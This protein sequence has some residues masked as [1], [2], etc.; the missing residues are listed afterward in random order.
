MRVSARRRHEAYVT[1]NGVPHDVKF[2]GFDSMNRTVDGD[3]VVFAIDP[4]E[5]WP[6]LE[7][8]LEKKKKRPRAPTARARA[9]GPSRGRGNA[10]RAPPRRR[11]RRRE[12]SRTRIS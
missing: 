11:R 2:D 10:K 7:E 5:Y 3:V 12:T 4:V 1:V 8:R 6:P 9:G